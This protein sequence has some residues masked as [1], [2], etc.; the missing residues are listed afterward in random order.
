SSNAGTF[1]GL[2]EQAVRAKPPMAAVARRPLSGRDI[3]IS[4]RDELR[5]DGNSIQCRRL[6]TVGGNHDGGCRTVM[7]GQPPGWCWLVAPRSV[8][9]LPGWGPRILR[10]RGHGL[11]ARDQLRLRRRTG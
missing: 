11:G 6:R 7:V 3:C 9:A 10:Q 2:S 8:R 4:L 1:E 5:N